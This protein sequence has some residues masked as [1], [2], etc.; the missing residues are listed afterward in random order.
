MRVRI[1]TEKLKADLKAMGVPQT[2]IGP[3]M[4]K[5]TNWLSYLLNEGAAD[6]KTVRALEQTLFKPEGH[7]EL[8]EAEPVQDSGEAV[9]LLQE[10]V[11][12][13]CVIKA[14]NEEIIGAL[15]SW[16]KTNTE[17][18]AKLIEK[19]TETLTQT[20]KVRSAIDRATEDKK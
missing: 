17:Q 18:C 3:R 6:E 16:R 20:M 7:Y 8:K 19:T 13:L 14:Q 5:S 10:V 11:K 12:H 9:K 4:G 1:D 15:H 2:A